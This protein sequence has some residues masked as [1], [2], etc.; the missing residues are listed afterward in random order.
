MHWRRKW[1]PTPVFLPGE[2]WKW[3][4]LVVSDSQW[5][6]GLQPT[7]LLHPW[8]FPGKSTGVGCH[9][10]KP[11]LNW[12]WCVMKS[13]FYTTWLSDFTFTFRFHA[14][15]KEVATHSGVLAWRIPG[16]GEP[17]GLPSMGVAQ[18]RT[19]LKRL[20]SSS[21]CIKEEKMTLQNDNIFDLLSAR[22][23]P[24]IELFY[25]SS[26]LQMPNNH[27]LVD[28]EFLGNFLCSCKRISFDDPLSWS[29]LTSDGRPLHSSP[30]RLLP[31][32]QNFLY[33]HRT[34][35]SLAAPRSHALL[36]LWVVCCFMTHF[37]LK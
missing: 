21:S 5:P 15:E 2:K 35:H 27:R 11:F 31:C 37:E 26:L 3:S 19:R 10:N 20:S 17:G 23:H 24:F 6:H 18:S 4:C 8:D 34:V 14:L 7:R 29:L 16:I 22:E 13:A 9:C 12:I 1:Q 33:H 32:L 28:V 36:M 25:L 30:L